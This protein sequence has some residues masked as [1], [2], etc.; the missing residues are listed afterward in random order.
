MSCH[1]SQAIRWKF[2]AVICKV[3]DSQRRQRLISIWRCWPTVIPWSSNWTLS[4]CRNRS[5]KWVSANRQ[6][7]GAL[8]YSSQSSVSNCWRAGSAIFTA[9]AK[10][11]STCP[12]PRCARKSAS[13]VSAH[14]HRLSGV[15][16]ASL[17]VYAPAAI[18]NCAISSKPRSRA[19]SSGVLPYLSVRCGL[20][21]CSS[22]NC[23]IACC[24]IPPSLSTIA[25]SSGV[26]PTWLVWLTLISVCAK[27]SFTIL[28]W[29]FSQAG[30]RPTPP[31]R[32]TQLRS[33]LVGKI[34]RSRVKSSFRQLIKKGFKQVWSCLLISAPA[35][36]NAWTQAYCWYKL[37]SV[38]AVFPDDRRY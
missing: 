37:A 20:A 15:L 6:L 12:C 18:S 31:K 22:N 19:S 16:I 35:S 17:P 11:C 21:P 32:V 24:L 23:T 34:I 36:I 25:S 13:A 1:C 7:F 3:G 28:K 10:T 14:T 26:Q 9:L 38:I 27:S 5:S 8:S 4:P 33:G 2:T 29:P 30:V